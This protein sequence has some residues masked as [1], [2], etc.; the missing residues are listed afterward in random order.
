MAKYSKTLMVKPGKAELLLFTIF[1]YIAKT[2]KNF[3]V[4]FNN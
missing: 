3:E 2:S 1:Q 4:K